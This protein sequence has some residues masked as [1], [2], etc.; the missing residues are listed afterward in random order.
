MKRLPLA[1]LIAFGAFYLHAQQTPTTTSTQPPAPQQ[2]QDSPLVRA[3]KAAGK[4]T[5]KS[6][7]KKI[8]IT[9]ETLSRSGGHLTTSNAAPQPL[10]VIPNS[11]AAAE[12]QEIQRK[13]AAQVAAADKARQEA[14][15]KKKAAAAE[16]ANAVYEGDDAEGAY[17]DPALVEG[18][19][20]KQSPAPPQQPPTIQVRKPPTSR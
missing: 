1:L 10:P 16:H 18:R 11:N 4:T 12:A 3:A 7:K 9:N 17:E 2:Q 19:A 8:V 14:E 6:H 13:I 20:E 15:A 5:S